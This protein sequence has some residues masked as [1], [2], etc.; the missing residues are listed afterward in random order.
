[1]VISCMASVQHLRALYAL[2]SIS[3]LEIKL[4]LATDC[5]CSRRGVEKVAIC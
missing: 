2:L 4:G 3:P 1:M 5:Q